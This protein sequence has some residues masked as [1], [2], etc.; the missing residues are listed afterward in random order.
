M[1]MGPQGNQA[2]GVEAQPPLTHAQST[3]CHAWAAPRSPGSL[4]PR[5]GSLVPGAQC[6]LRPGGRKQVPGTGASVGG[7]GTG[8]QAGAQPG[9]MLATLQR[10]WAPAM[11]TEA[12][13]TARTTGRV[14]PEGKAG[15]ERIS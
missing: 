12:P 15:Q 1:Y 6:E 11:P 4:R 13:V 3:E 2:L 14:R 5:E 7:T 10:A 9:V 8:V